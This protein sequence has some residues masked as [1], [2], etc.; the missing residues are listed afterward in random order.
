MGRFRDFSVDDEPATTEPVSFALAG[1]Q[2]VCVANMPPGAWVDV[3]RAADLHPTGAIGVAQMNDFIRAVLRDPCTECG[4][5]GRIR[6][7]ACQVCGGEPT[8]DIARFEAIIRSKTTYVPAGTL[9]DIFN[10][11]LEEYADRPFSPPRG[12]GDGESSSAAGS[13]ASG[14]SQG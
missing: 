12:S 10:W 2:F 11:M 7:N 4:G 8:D 14:S 5:S 6:R 3:M 13:T 1:E 9:R